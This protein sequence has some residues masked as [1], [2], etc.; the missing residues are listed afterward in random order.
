MIPTFLCISWNLLVGG[1]ATDA[2]FITCFVFH[3]QLT[4]LVLAAEF[5]S[6]TLKP[7]QSHRFSRNQKLYHHHPP[8]PQKF[9]GTK[10]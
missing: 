6:Q 2:V 5:P 8:P 10:I 3:L 7:K 4:T 9:P 1:A